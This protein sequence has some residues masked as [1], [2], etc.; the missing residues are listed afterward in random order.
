[1]AADKK[2][3]ELQEDIERLRKENETLAEELARAKKKHGPAATPV[4]VVDVGPTVQKS[5]AEILDRVRP[6]R[7][8]PVGP[9]DLRRRRIEMG[10]SMRASLAALLQRQDAEE[11][12]KRVREFLRERK[13][14]E[15][16]IDAQVR[17]ASK[18]R[19]ATILAH[20]SL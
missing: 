5:L 9:R 19:L 10:A 15:E 12:G 7:P 2:K 20:R 14:P 18:E 6:P 1:M 3:A 13:M 11:L 8:A 4:V 16:Q 17:D